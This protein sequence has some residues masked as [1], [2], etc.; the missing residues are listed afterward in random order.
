M[1][2]LNKLVSIKI[3]MINVIYI[4]L[5]NLVLFKHKE[6]YNLTNN[7][8]LVEESAHFNFRQIN[9]LIIKNLI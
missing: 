9:N 3:N 5:N 2:Y 8:Y 1:K 7:S 6:I 4:Y